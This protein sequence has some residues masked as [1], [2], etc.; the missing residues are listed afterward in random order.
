MAAQT[1]WKSKGQLGQL[2]RRLSH[3][4]GSRKAIKAVARRLAVIFYTMI[5]KQTK[6]DPVSVVMDE[7]K[8][9]ARKLARL[10]KEAAKLGGKVVIVNS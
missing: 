7:E 8:V 10:N 9:R 3:S 2:Y 5:S 6:Y 4:K 1:M